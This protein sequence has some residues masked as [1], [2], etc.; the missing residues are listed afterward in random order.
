MRFRNRLFLL[1]LPLIVAPTAVTG[2]L[3]TVQ[4]GRAL[5]D[6]E[7]S[8][9]EARVEQAIGRAEEAVTTL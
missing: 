5:R 7:L 4:T 3:M 8:F 6:L 2:V 9:L 1:I